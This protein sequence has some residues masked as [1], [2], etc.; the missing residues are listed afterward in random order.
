MNERKTSHT[1]VIGM[2]R[3]LLDWHQS[4]LAM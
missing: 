2:V 1:V 4:D 3:S